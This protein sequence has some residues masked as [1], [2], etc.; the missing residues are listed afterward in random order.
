[1][2]DSKK[3]AQKRKSDAQEESAGGG[4]EHSVKK[5]KP[6]P[7]KS[8]HVAGSST[9]KT[10]RSSGGGGKNLK[11]FKSAV[12]IFVC[13]VVLF[14]SNTYFFSPRIRLSRLMSR[15]RFQ[16]HRKVARRQVDWYLLFLAQNLRVK[17]QSRLRY[18]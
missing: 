17:K 4:G 16:S 6:V 18:V 7:V 9:L 2:N 3:G 8:E 13:Q 5:S 1:M 14:R 10:K 15:T 12:R 11:T